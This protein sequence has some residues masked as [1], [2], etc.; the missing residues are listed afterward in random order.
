MAIAVDGPPIPV[1]SDYFSLVPTAR[2]ARNSGFA[3]NLSLIRKR[4]YPPARDRRA[5]SAYF[6]RVMLVLSRIWVASPVSLLF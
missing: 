1:E 3:Q 4:F 6:A 2:R 5:K